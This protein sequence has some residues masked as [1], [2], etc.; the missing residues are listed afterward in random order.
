MVA[1]REGRVASER[2]PEAVECGDQA[3]AR[4]NTSSAVAV[5]GA[6]QTPG[7]QMRRPVDTSRGPAF[8]VTSA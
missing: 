5:R 8:G 7:A 1:Q 4:L 6:A 2:L 3:V